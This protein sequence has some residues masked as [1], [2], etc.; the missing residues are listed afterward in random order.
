LAAADR[1]NLKHAGYNQKLSNTWHHFKDRFGGGG[2]EFA[3]CSSEAQGD[4]LLKKLHNYVLF[5]LNAFS[6]F[7]LFI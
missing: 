5:F 1:A 3:N 7:F 6:H 4:R 2:K